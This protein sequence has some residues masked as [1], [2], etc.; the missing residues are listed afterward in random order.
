MLDDI[1]TTVSGNDR[2]VGRGDGLGPNEIL[3]DPKTVATQ[4]C[5][6]RAH[7]RLKTDVA[8]A[9]D[10]GRAQAYL[11][12]LDGGL[13]LAQMRKGL[14]NPVRAMTSRKMSGIP[15]SACAFGRRREVLEGSRV[16]QACRGA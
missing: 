2:G 6:F 16:H 8:G 5:K 11:E 12:V 10:Q 15:P 7:D 13:T 4:S 14:A 3:T 9:A 1:Q